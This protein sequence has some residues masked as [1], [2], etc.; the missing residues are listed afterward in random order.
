[1]SQPHR[2]KP[3]A[4]TG[5]GNLLSVLVWLAPLTLLLLTASV[6]GYFY[7]FPMPVL[8]K[9][10]AKINPVEIEPLYRQINALQNKNNSLVGALALA[11]RS[12]EID[13]E[14]AKELQITLSER[15]KE[16]RDLREEL[17]FL[18]SMVSPEE[19]K[20]G[21]GIRSF[22]L[23]ATGKSRHYAF[24]LVLI[25]VGK[26]DRVEVIKGLVKIRVQGR[27]G[28]KH[29][30]LSWEGMTASGTNRLRF[31]F[32]F[33]QRLSGELILPDNFEPENVL[34][35]AEPSSQ[36]YPPFQKIYAWASVYGAGQ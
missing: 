12:A 6:L 28:G 5:H 20:P 22:V 11:R 25:R 8:E 15:E 23:R 35:K 14:A 2:V 13:A 16:M 29:K 24:K 9:P 7:V 1:M 27:E 4:K 30:T 36:K 34:V 3:T 17:N 31:N 32:Q 21:L 19:T 26:S 18:R 10:V 33:F